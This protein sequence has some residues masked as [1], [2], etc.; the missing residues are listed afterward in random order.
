[1]I[2][3]RNGLGCWVFASCSLALAI[4]DRGEEVKIYGKKLGMVEKLKKH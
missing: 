3:C 1:V 2:T 4:R